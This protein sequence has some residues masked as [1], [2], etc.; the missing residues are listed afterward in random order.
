MPMESDAAEGLFGRDQVERGRRYHRPLYL[1]L[2]ANT[3]IGL[4]VLAALAF[5]G[6]DPES[7]PWWAAACAL[8]A[9]AV[10]AP[11]LARTPLAFWAG[12]L[13]ERRFGF[14]TQTALGW[15]ADRAKGLAV[16]LAITV[17]LMLGFV[18]LARAL[19]ELWP[20]AAAGGAAAAILVV[21]F[22]APVA[23]EPLFNRFVPLADAELAGELRSLAD[24]AGTPIQDVLV[25]DASRRT[26]KVNAYVSGLG[27][28]RRVVVFDTLL[29]QADPRETRLVVA[30]ELG[31]RKAGH[32]VKGTLL[33]MV[34]AAAGVFCIWALLRWPA[35]LD[36]IGATGPGDPRVVPFV[37]LAISVLELAALPAGAA[38]S[39]RWE[40][41]ADALSLELTHDPDAFEEA[42]RR[43]AVANL[44]DLDPP[45]LAYVLLFTHPT[46]AERI[47]SARHRRG[48]GAPIPV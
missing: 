1:G 12:H 8:A 10:V 17:P 36:A 38:L 2:A 47:A 31:H 44:A 33:G 46:Q 19:P 9:L 48:G 3:A 26:R 37:L 7:W 24:R 41:E 23:I 20:V 6:P 25:A 14:S 42:H 15:F 45:R 5:V 34:G 11:S 18:V 39:R 30:H 32:L 40:R 29:E 21:G 13:R 27:R 28:T 35:L 4:G 43:L 22:L 16:G